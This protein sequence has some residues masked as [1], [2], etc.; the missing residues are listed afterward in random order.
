MHMSPINAITVEKFDSNGKLISSWGYK[1]N[2]EGEFSHLHAITVDSSGNVYVSEG[3]E[4]LRIQKFV[5]NGN[6]ISKWGL[7]GIDY[8]HL[9]LPQDITLGSNNSVYIADAGNAHTDI[10]FID[11]FLSKHNIEISEFC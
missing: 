5:S 11:M 6:F 4:F 3:R 9:L 7:R 2:Q 8:N 1:G 10:R